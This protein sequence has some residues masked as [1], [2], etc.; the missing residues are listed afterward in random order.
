MRSI[1]KQSLLRRRTKGVVLM[2]KT[3]FLAFFAALL[4]LF[5]LL[6]SSCAAQEPGEI[7]LYGEQ[8]GRKDMMDQEFEAW[9]KFYHEEG[10]RD[11][12]LEYPCYTAEYLN[13]WMNAENDEILNQI[14]KDTKGTA[15]NNHYLLEFLQKI[16]QEC[17]ET[18]FHGT[19]VGHQY[20]T[21]GVRFLK[22]L[23]ETGQKD[24]GLYRQAQECMAQGVRFYADG[25]GKD[26]A[27]RETM[28]VENFC[29]EYERAGKPK[30]MGIYGGAHVELGAQA[31]MAPDLRNMAT[32]LDERYPGLVKTE[33][34]KKVS[35]RTYDRQ[36]G[37][38][39]WK[40]KS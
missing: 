3:R 34:L 27:Y 15:A 13:L 37:L 14:Y 6:F 40:K 1:K 18:V 9:S 29:A 7:Y 22:H 12:F 36:H 8:H 31:Y 19:D 32:Q 39:N 2:S 26:W 11:L 38:K 5:S 28:M 25:E 4:I 10:M 16:K 33:I 23:E 20:N 21:T 30:L 24:S 35:K 17:P